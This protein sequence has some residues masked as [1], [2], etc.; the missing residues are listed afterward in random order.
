MESAKTFLYRQSV[1]SNHL[2]LLLN[3]YKMICL[4][5]PNECYIYSVPMNF[6]AKY[7]CLCFKTWLIS[8]KMATLKNSWNIQSRGLSGAV[9]SSAIAGCYS[10]SG[11]FLVCILFGLGGRGKESQP[12]YWCWT[13]SEHVT[14]PIVQSHLVF[15]LNVFVATLY[16][17]VFSKFVT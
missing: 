15:S 11:F 4:L 3:I 17:A 8:F 6:I 2:L 9:P 5:V 16:T 7:A 14:T 12:C 1:R 13:F 10:C